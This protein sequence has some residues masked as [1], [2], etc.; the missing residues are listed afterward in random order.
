[1]VYI[2]NSLNIKIKHEIFPVLIQGPLEAQ[3][4]ELSDLDVKI[5]KPYFDFKDDNLFLK[6][7]KLEAFNKSKYLA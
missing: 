5:S 3:L 6:I 2:T 4:S 1:M 7:D